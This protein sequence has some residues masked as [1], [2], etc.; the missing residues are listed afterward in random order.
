LPARHLNYIG[1][2][3]ENQAG[4]EFDIWN[5]KNIINISRSSILI[6]NEAIIWMTK[7][8][9]TANAI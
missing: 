3:R 7:S 6:I 8:A 2:M 4:G 1:N 9:L 5:F